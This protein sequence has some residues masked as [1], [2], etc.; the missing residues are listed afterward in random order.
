MLQTHGFAHDLPN[1]TKSVVTTSLHRVGNFW[2]YI[3]I[4][5]VHSTGHKT[6]GTSTELADHG[7]HSTPFLGD[8]AMHT[9]GGAQWVCFDFIHRIFSV[10]ITLEN[11]YKLVVARTIS[12]ALNQAPDHLMKIPHMMSCLGSVQEILHIE[13]LYTVC[14]GRGHPR[15]AGITRGSRQVNYAFS[16]GGP[17]SRASAGSSAWRLEVFTAF[18]SPCSV[19]GTG[20]KDGTLWAV[21]SKQ[22]L[23]GGTSNMITNCCYLVCRPDT[24]RSTQKLP[25]DSLGVPIPSQTVHHAASCFRTVVEITSLDRCDSGRLGH[26]LKDSDTGS[27]QQF[28]SPS[29]ANL[30]TLVGMK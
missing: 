14:W 29:L 18:G 17:R 16:L 7:A 12:L 27:H 22:N 15:N 5:W 28:F 21:A 23:G 24:Y 1:D 25:S 26:K 2:L 9:V 10:H 13:S 30:L 6:A 4:T 11:N 8:S 3:T 20:D 19:G